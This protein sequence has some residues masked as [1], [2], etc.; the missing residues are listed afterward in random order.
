[1]ADVS[2]VLRAARERS[3]LS[4]EE[5][6][7]RTKIKLTFLHAIERGEFERLPGEFFARAFLRTYARE[8]HLSPDAVLRRYD[9]GRPAVEQSE[10]E[11][12]SPA[13]M[14][15][16]PPPGP[17]GLAPWQGEGEGQP[18]LPAMRYLWP[19]LA[20]AAILVVAMFVTPRPGPDGSNEVG[21]VGTAGV[22]AAEVAHAALD[23]APAAEPEPDVLA[24]EI[25]ASGL[26]WVEAAADGERVIYR[27]LQPGDRAAV[28]ARDALSIRVGNAA[29]FE[30]SINGLPGRTLGGEGDVRDVRITRENYRTF[31]R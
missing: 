1:M 27:L 7:D 3:G 13:R 24:F 16:D 21:A 23:V 12:R 20:F 2:Q 15:D 8:L 9:A 22:E 29:A 28:E 14:A 4:L 18:A 6:S 30:Y 31:Q 25:R 19:V 17:S 11:G 10:E 5:V 26:T